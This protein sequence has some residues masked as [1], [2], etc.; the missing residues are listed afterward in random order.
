M[1]RRRRV[2]LLCLTPREEVDGAPYESPSY[3]IRRIQAAVVADPDLRDVE[4][5]LFE[6]R[7]LPAEEAVARVEAYDPDV[8][9]S[10]VYVWSFPPLLEIARRLKENRG[11][12]TIVFGGPSARP[13]MFALEPFRDSLEFV[14]AIVIREGEETFREIV[15]LRERNRATLSHVRGIAVPTPSGWVETEA[16]PL[17]E[18]LDQIASPYQ[19]GLMPRGQFGYLETYRGCPLSCKFCEWGISGGARRVFSKDYLVRELEA[20]RDADAQGAFN[21]DA[22]LNLNI[23]AFRNLAAAEAEV[24]FF[25]ERP[26]VCEFYPTQ[27]NDEYFEFLRACNNG[28]IGVGL[29]TFSRE[30]LKAMERPFM[31]ARFEWVVN[32]LARVGPVEIQVI[33]GLPG[34]DPVSFKNTIERARRLP[35]QVSVYHCLVLP[36]A[37]M[38]RGDPEFDLKFDPYT[39]RMISCQG[40]SEQALAETRAWLIEQSAHPEPGLEPSRE[41]WIGFDR[42]HQGQRTAESPAEDSGGTTPAR[43]PAA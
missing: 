30:A 31:E 6:M 38:T 34:D 12:R 25:R 1:S 26:L 42:P 20:L 21:L 43:P 22:G 37:L 39:L 18:P 29:Q 16:R 33:L 41:F 9:G 2:A 11:D 27:I 4:V 40:W 15:G 5:E 10:S 28:Y 8:V 36:D 3:G 24:R 7:D 23:H 13:A 17:L 19:Y 35:A 14:D 32:E